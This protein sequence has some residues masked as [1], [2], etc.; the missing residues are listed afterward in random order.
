MHMWNITMK[1]LCT[2][3]ICKNGEKFIWNIWPKEIY[4]AEWYGLY[5]NIQNLKIIKVLKS[6]DIKGNMPHWGKIAY[7]L[8]SQC[9]LL[10]KVLMDCLFN[11][12]YSNNWL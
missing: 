7:A 12:C 9:C 11:E 10:G 6:L 5:S 8:S 1:P 2:T 4:Q 3:N